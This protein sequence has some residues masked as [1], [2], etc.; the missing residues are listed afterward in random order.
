MERISPSTVPRSVRG[1]TRYDQSRQKPRSVGRARRGKRRKHQKRVVK[2]PRRPV[3]S[4]G[5]T[6]TTSYYNTLQV[7]EPTIIK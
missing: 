4:E 6:W 7:L 3:K 1:K 5:T 2:N